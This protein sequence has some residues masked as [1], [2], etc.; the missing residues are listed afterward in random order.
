MLGWC[1]DIEWWE[2]YF[3][4]MIYVV[5]TSLPGLLYGC[6]VCGSYFLRLSSIWLMGADERGS[7]GQQGNGD[8]VA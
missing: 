1:M 6:L 2:L 3:D 7:R 5:G 4:C 8:S